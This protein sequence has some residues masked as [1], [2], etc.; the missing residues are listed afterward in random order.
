MAKIIS[1]SERYHQVRTSSLPPARTRQEY[2]KK[3]EE[4][5]VFT[6]CICTELTGVACLMRLNFLFRVW[7]GL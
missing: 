7:I 5:L 6:L 1:S 2:N 4:Y 3:G